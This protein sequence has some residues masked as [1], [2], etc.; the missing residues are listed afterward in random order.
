MLEHNPQ[1]NVSKILDLTAIVGLAIER[2]IHWEAC[3]DEGTPNAITLNG[4]LVSLE[5]VARGKRP[6]AIFV[7]VGNN[8]VDQHPMVLL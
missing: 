2:K 7:D 5:M 4:C 3:V 6:H 8:A 1:C